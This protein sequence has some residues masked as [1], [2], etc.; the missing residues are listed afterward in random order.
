MQREQS[1]TRS[2]ANELD[3]A[4]RLG[5]QRGKTIHPVIVPF[6]T[7]RETTMVQLASPGTILPEVVAVST[8]ESEL[9]IN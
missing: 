2:Q 7:E 9:W 1:D 6:T 4:E 8:N 3:T 5:D